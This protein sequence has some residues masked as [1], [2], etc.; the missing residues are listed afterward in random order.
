MIVGNSML[1]S[2]AQVHLRV[3]KKRGQIS[4]DLAIW[5]PESFGSSPEEGDSLRIQLRCK[6]GSR[7]S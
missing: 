5:C 2:N 6:E 1:S 3:I 7:K 4:S